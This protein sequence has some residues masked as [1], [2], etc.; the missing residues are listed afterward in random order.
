M[1]NNQNSPQTPDAAPPRLFPSFA[2]GFNT[3]ASNIYLIII[4]VVLDLL[5]WFGPHLRLKSL[6]LPWILEAI[7]TVRESGTP[8]ASE[9][10]VGMDEIWKLFLERYN[11][12]SSISTFPL[13]IPSLM[14]SYSPLLTPIGNAP[15]QEITSPL[16]VPLFWVLF[17]VFGFALGSIYFSL[18]ANAFRKNPAETA[19]SPF[20]IRTLI[21]QTTQMV[22]LVLLLTLLL[23]IIMLPT[24][25][26]SSVLVLLS[27]VL[28]WIVVLAMT[29][30]A[31]W[32]MIPLIFTPHGIFSMR[33]NV[34]QS[35][36]TSVRLVRQVLPGTGLFILLSIILY[37]G[38]G[39]LWRIPPETSW[40]ALVGIFGHAFISTSVVASSFVYYLNCFTWVQAAARRAAMRTV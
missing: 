14:A 11:L 16:L 1:V 23:I 36:L 17:S 3:V 38:L 10:L 5:L 6:V 13:G 18:L 39:V 2:H 8:Q 22:F 24:L 4:P 27:P 31:V 40:M 25:V 12:L 7:Q 20:H 21:W 30:L 9:M 15:V 29:F 28:S 37:Q 35:A 26:I 32:L 34:I 33:Q 19:P